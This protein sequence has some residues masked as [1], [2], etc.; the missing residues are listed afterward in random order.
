MQT[1]PNPELAAQLR[2]VHC[3]SNLGMLTWVAD[4]GGCCVLTSCCKAFRKLHR[5]SRYYN[6]VHLRGFAESFHNIAVRIIEP[7]GL[8]SM[9][10][11]Y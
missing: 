10:D 4:M 11:N 5:C 3:T 6:P 8:Q 1:V 2:K 7:Y 9:Q